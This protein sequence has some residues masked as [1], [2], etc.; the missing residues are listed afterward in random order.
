M[1]ISIADI[2]KNLKTES[3]Q[4]EEYDWYDVENTPALSL[5]GV[6]HDGTQY[7]RMP[8]DIAST[9]S[10][11]VEYLAKHTAGGRV[12]FQTCSPRIA[13]RVILPQEPL[14]PHMPATGS[15]GTSVYCNGTYC[16][17]VKPL[18]QNIARAVDNDEPI[19]CDGVVT[20]PLKQRKTYNTITVCTPLY[21]GVYKMYIGVEKG[22]DII[23]PD[24]YTH[25]KPVVFYGSSIT[26]GGCASHPGAEYIGLLS[27][28]LD[29]D[30]INLGFSGSGK[31]E[32]TMVEYLASLDASVFVLDYDHNAP[33]PEHLQNTHYPL[34]AR[35]REMHPQTPIVFMTKPDCDND[36]FG[37]KRR[38]II[39]ATYTQAKKAG[40]SNVYFIDGK[41]YYGKTRRDLYA[42]DGCHPTDLGFYKMA[43]TVYP[44]L[45]K[46]LN[47]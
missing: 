4:D 18:P 24:P 17:G 27:N 38:A 5:H 7:R 39:R 2:D 28:W 14:M 19:I 10:E 41:R 1:K 34:Y 36:P 37:T 29:F 32:P 11:G 30:Y 6:Y 22:Y 16:N 45:D 43:K 12:R 33:T 31:A 42:V 3:A 35:I 47:G 23:A 9:V 46:I 44:V 26:Q 21:C 20:L 8:A 15:H 40:D 13:M 25:E